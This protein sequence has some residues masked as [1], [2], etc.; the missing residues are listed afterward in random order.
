MRADHFAPPPGHPLHAYVLAIFRVRAA[1]AYRCETILPKGNV[2]LLFNLGDDLGVAGDRLGAHGIA[3]S[4]VRVAGLQ[5]RPI[6]AVPR[7][8]VDT[9]GVSLRV[10]ACAALLPAPLDGLA[11]RAVAGD[12]VLPG[13]RALA[14]RLAAAEDF[15]AQRDLL[16]RWL[17]DRLRPRRGADA[18]ARACVLLRAGASDQAVRDAARAAAVSPRHLQR[19]FVDQIGVGPAD[20]AR[21]ARFVDA[22]HLTAAST[23]TLTAVAHATRYHDQAHLCRD[24]RT[25]AAM[26][27]GE[28]RAQARGPAVGHLFAP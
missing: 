2:D 23:H 27:P 26:T 8:T 14:E 15:A 3:A 5:T 24:F 22:L 12:D 10:E 28:Y 19:L 7:G 25:F 11:D 1:G 20:Y 4:S 6:A 9:L 16:V 21:L 13:A 17:V 18:I